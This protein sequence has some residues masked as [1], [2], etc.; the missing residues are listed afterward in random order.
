MK[1]KFWNLE[2]EIMLVELVECDLLKNNGKKLGN[3]NYEKITK[4]FKNRNVSSIRHH[5]Y[6]Q[7]LYIQRHN[8][9]KHLLHQIKDLKKQ[10]LQIKR[11]NNF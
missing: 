4:L 11:T 7:L 5:L 1:K 9:N 3:I 6:Y 8:K 2:E 10:L